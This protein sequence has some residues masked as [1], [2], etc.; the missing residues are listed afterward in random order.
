[1]TPQQF[2][3]TLRAR[4][5]VVLLAFAA[6]VVSVS[7]LTLTAERQFTAAASVVLD[8]KSPDAVTG[9][10]L[11][12]MMSPAYMATQVDIVRSDRVAR[13]V[14]RALRIDQSA[15]ARAQWMQ[16]TGGQGEFEG[17]IA[18]RLQGGLNVKPSRES[19][20]IAIEYT[21]GDPAFAA[22]VANAFAQAYIDINL[23][24]RTE[25][26]RQFAN[27]FDEQTRDARQRLEQAQQALTAFQRRTGITAVDGR[28]DVETARLNDISAQLSALRAQTTD[29]ASKRRHENGETIAE[30]MQSPLVN[31]LRADLARREATLQELS[32]NFG[33]N[34]P[35]AQRVRSEIATLRTQLD[36]ETQRIQASIDTTYTISRQRERQ[37]E[38]ALAAQRNRVLDLNRERDQIAVLQ[39]D[40]ESAQRTFD[41]LAQ[42]AAQTTVESRTTQTN[43][44]VLNPATPPA[45]PSGPRV[46]LNI[47]IAVFLGALLGVVLAMGLELVSRRVRSLPDLDALPGVPVL[48]A[49]GPAAS[50]FKPLA[51]WGAR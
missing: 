25:P 16:A 31:G 13:R 17:W 37:L 48:G 10:M 50:M 36:A 4:W 15:A 28:L 51:A 45:Q 5:L 42:R 12:G 26:A 6:V 3:A 34:H 39:R 20:V 38:A 41:V 23:E 27:F 30:V 19:N 7:A 18:G 9:A 22:A 2:F 43:I 14:V 24:L 8:V 49:V 40:V 47:A 21:A 1:M 35:Q 29:S 44:T 11:A 33:P 32:V 46:R